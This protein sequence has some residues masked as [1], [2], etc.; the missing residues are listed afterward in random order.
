[1]ASENQPPAGNP[2]REPRTVRMGRNGR[3]I[4]EIAMPDGHDNVTCETFDDARRAAYLRATRV[5]PCELIVRDAYGRVVQR[6]LIDGDRE[7]S[8][9]RRGQLSG[10]P[11]DLSVRN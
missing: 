5:F 6:E 11:V 7:A 8:Q 3:G 4:W 9:A 1:M 10:D 2:G